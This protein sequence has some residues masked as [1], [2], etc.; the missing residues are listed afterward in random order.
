MKYSDIDSL[1]HDLCRLPHRGAGTVYVKQAADALAEMLRDAGFEVE[2]QAFRTPATFVSVVY[3]LLGAVIAGMWLALWWGWPAVLLALLFATGGFL[4]L[5]WRPSF[6]IR[7]PPRVAEENVI[8]RMPASNPGAVR[9]KL[10]LM[11]HYDTAPVSELY[12]KQTPQGFRNTVRI[13]M[14]LLPVAVGAAVLLWLSPDSLPVM[15]LAA[16][17]SVYFLAQGIMS[18]I[19]FWRSGFTNGASDNA[20]GVAA[21]Y[22]SALKL[23]EQAPQWDVEV[24]FTSAEEAGMIGALFYRE[25]CRREGSLPD[26]LLNFDTLGRG[27]LKVIIQTGSLTTIRYDNAL[28]HATRKAIASTPALQHIGEGVWHTADFDSAWFARAG[29][30]CLTLAC[31]DERGAMPGIHRPEDTLDSVSAKGV[32]DAVAL[33]GGIISSL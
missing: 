6:L 31:L 14:L 17:L 28:L 26:V 15:V 27:A 18:T 4:Y 32:E 19:G 11:A 3:W 2:R 30:P 25:Q 22:F 1:L 16:A 21:A 12:R 23:R 20:T 13:S 5:D 33:A 7:L 9:R 29:I 10:T 24:V 8:G